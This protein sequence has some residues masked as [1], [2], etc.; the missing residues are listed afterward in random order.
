MMTELNSI[1]IVC[2]YCGTANA[3]PSEHIGEEAIC[4]GCNDIMVVTPPR[5]KSTRKRPRTLPVSRC[6]PLGVA[7]FAAI[8]MTAVIALIWVLVSGV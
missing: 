7:M 5:P 1:T 3:F 4:R 6:N 2:R 8:S